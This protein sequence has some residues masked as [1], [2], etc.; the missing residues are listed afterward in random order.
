MPFVSNMDNEEQNPNPNMAPQG[1]VAPIGGG[2]VRLAPS[3]A[4]APAGGGG[5]GGAPSAAAT[6]AGGQFASLQ[7]YLAANQGQAEPLA[8][9]LSTGINQQYSTLQGQN[10]STLNDINKAVS[11]NALPDSTTTMAWEAANPV[12][13]AKNPGNVASFQNLLN[14]TY[15]GPTSAESTSG[16][17]AQQNAINNAINTGQ[18]ATKTEAGRENL[19][20]QNEA[21]PT[22]GVTALNSAILSQSP[23]A[24][25]SVESAYEPFSNLLT[26]L[27]SGA[28]DVNKNIAKTQGD[29]STASS[30]ANKQ[31]SDQINA[32][33]TG[34]T[35]STNK[36][37]ADQNARNQ[38]II[39]FQNK[40]GTVSTDINVLNELVPQILGAGTPL[41]ANPFTSILNTPQSNVTYTP[42]GIAT[43]DDAAKAQAFSQLLSGLNLGVP[44]P[45]ITQAGNQVAPTQF[46]QPN[47]DQM[48][49]D[50]WN[51][52]NATASSKNWTNPYDYVLGAD[53]PTN[54]PRWEQIDPAFTNLY[55]TLSQIAP[56]VPRGGRG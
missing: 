49:N 42:Q 51:T 15:G 52:S 7:N 9:K 28:Q 35:T 10:T 43:A 4:I 14:A 55:Q 11:A 36:D 17:G 44:T 34:L 12:S 30:A 37:I 48:A 47:I 3:A 38:A 21:T 45:L 39:D 1:A 54:A 25:K 40:Y 16:F 2:S 23:T 32:L 41:V 22:A 24:L 13:F 20:T 50:I 18:Q 27:T 53:N 8:G 31:I 6:P 19:L 33:N 5:S 56:N 29:I 26:G 46:V